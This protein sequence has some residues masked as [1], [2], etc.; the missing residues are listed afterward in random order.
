MKFWKVLTL[1]VQQCSS[2]LKW[3][4]TVSN[5]F[6]YILIKTVENV[7]YQDILTSVYRKAK[8]SGQYF[9]LNS[10]NFVSHKIVFVKTLVHRA[11]KYCTNV[12]A[13]HL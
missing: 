8:F 6:S 10:E 9:N 11:K 3:K 12:E 5:P 1:F 4:L 2:K 13:L 7:T